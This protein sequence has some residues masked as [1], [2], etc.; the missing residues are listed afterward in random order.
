MKMIKLMVLACLSAF[1]I[2][3]SAQDAKA[4]LIKAMDQATVDWNKGNLDGYMALYAPN[5]TMMMP[6]GRVGLSAIRDL[7]VK[8]YFENGQP[9]Q[10]LAYTNYEVTMLG[11]NYALL[12]GGF[13]L[14]ANSKFKE[15]KGT[16]SLVFVHDK[17]GWKLL[18]DHSG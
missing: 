9:K 14:K 13:T 3:A 1:T 12:T 4:E 8:Y 2:N 5:A 6:T 18:H 10:E 11:K 7:Y 16:F 15:R 17:T